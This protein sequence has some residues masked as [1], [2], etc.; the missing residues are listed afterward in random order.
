M[1]NPFKFFDYKFD[2]QKVKLVALRSIPKISLAGEEIGPVEENE[3]FEVKNWIADELVKNGYAKIVA[4]G[5]R[6]SLI[7]VQKAQVV[8]AIQSPRHLSILPENFYPKLRK[9]LKELEEKSQKDPTKKLEFQKIVQLAMDIVTSRLN[10]ILILASA[11]EKDENLLKN[12]TLEE[13]ALYEKL[14]Q[15]VNEWRNLIL[16]Y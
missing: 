16:K 2:H 7:D 4:E 14:Y 15:T 6:L 11:R 8:E 10:K 13:R 12:L 9:L 5:E 3:Y 1:D